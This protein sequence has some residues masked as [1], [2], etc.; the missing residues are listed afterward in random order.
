MLTFDDVWNFGEVFSSRM[1]LGFHYTGQMADSVYGVVWVSGF[2][3]STLL[4]EWP[5]V[6]VGL[7]YGQ[8]YGMDNEHGCI[9]L[10]AF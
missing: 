3:M 4:I 6:A 1:N 10:M 7:W 5:M 9:L 8:A 2:L